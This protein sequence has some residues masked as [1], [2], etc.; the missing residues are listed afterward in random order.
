VVDLVQGAE[1]GSPFCGF[2][3]HEAVVWTFFFED[4]GVGVSVYM[5]EWMLRLVRVLDEMKWMKPGYKEGVTR[6]SMC[7]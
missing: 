6:T 2:D 3:G 4:D 1:V 7:R 5:N